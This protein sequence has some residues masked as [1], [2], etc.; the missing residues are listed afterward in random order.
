MRHAC[1]PRLLVGLLICAVLPALCVADPA[2]R[3][4]IAGPR[5]LSLED[6]ISA[7]RAIEQV[8]WNHRIWPKENPGPKPALSTVLP[9]SALRTKVEDAL[10][11]SNALE[12]YWHRP[13]TAEQLQAELD[14]MAAHT[15]E[16]Q[17]LREMF[18]ALG[19]DP[20]LIGETLV[21]QALADRLIR[22]W[23]AKDE[24]FHGELKK[25]AEAALAT[26][27]NVECLPSMGGEYRETTW[28]LQD[29]KAYVPGSE[30]HRSVIGLEAEAWQSHLARLAGLL[31]GVPESL[32]LLKLSGLEETATGF[33]VTAVLLR[34]KSEV[35]AAT[36][37]WPKI[38]FDAWWQKQRGS[39]ADQ[40][41]AGSKT[42]TLPVTATSGCP[43]DTWAPMAA[44]DPIP[45]WHS[46]VWTGAEMIAWGGADW[47]AATYLNTGGRYDPST[48]T[49]TPTSA[50]PSVPSARFVNTAVWTGTEMI[51][52]GGY[53]ETDGYLNTGGR[54]NPSSDTWTPT[55]TGIDVPVARELH[56]AVWS[57][58]EMIVWGGYGYGFLG[59]SFLDTGARY[60]P[61]HDAWTP[62]STDRDVPAGRTY[63]TAVWTG[64]EMIVWG[65][66]DNGS[67]LNTGGRYYPSTNAWVP[68]STAANLPDGRAAHTAVWT[69]TEM[70]VWGGTDGTLPGTGGRYDPSSDS[71]APIS[72]GANDPSNRLYHT[73][74]W[75]GTEMVV[76]GGTDGALSGTGGRYDPSSDSWT[77]TSTGANDPEGRYQHTSVWTGTEMIVFGGLGSLNSGGLY[78]ACPSGTL[79]Y[80]DADGDGYG[81]GAAIGTACDGTVPTGY[82]ATSGDCNDGT[83][84]V[85]PGAVELC[86]GVDDNCD[87]AT[88]NAV[89]PG[90]FDS[91]TIVSDAQAVEWTAL[92]AAQTYDVVYGDLGVLHSSGG[93]YTAA[94]LGCLEPGTASTTATF[95][96][97]PEVG[98]AFWVLVRGDN[99]AGVGTYDSGVS[100]QVGSRDAGIA[101]SPFSCGYQPVCGDDVCNGTEDCSS[102]ASDCGVC[103]CLSDNDCQPNLCCY[104]T[105]CIPIWVPQACPFPI[106]DDQGPGITCVCQNGTCVGFF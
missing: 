45:Y 97:T 49:W 82:A 103:P 58:T 91:V 4:S 3:R 10:R 46:A 66:T 76:W 48:D 87:G 70:I 31:G 67:A 27:R 9:D 24:R 38:S 106:C 13:I 14:R 25:K 52:W 73:A 104:P 47:F 75:T 26:C 6:R 69:G 99:C 93:D 22:N 80:R 85:H 81:D 78:C 37:I 51:V 32:P 21:R 11:K 42:F 94:T 86:N 40:S 95:L 102:C 7:Q 77:S 28:R 53:N 62:T 101:A 105:D 20:R 72:T 89:P 68:T 43:A 23:Y 64:T 92:A 98:Q 15:R 100:S 57:G 50:G 41:D 5:S 30:P 12:K 88:D 61:S 59:D 17:V 33:M 36:V 2:P 39:L 71:W 90:P 83:G 63:H 16:P 18:A 65:G 34:G 54:Y 79:Y 29:G 84:S 96:P 60:D 1:I 74:V 35:R 55:W 44:T 56:T 19:N 8:Y